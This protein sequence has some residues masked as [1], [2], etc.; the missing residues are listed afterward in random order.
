[1]RAVI[2]IIMST[3]IGSLAHAQTPTPMP[4]PASG[5]YNYVD[6]DS[7]VF[8][9]GAIVCPF[10]RTLDEYRDAARQNCF[11]GYRTAP[12]AISNLWIYSSDPNELPGVVANPDGTFHIG[13]PRDHCR[14]SV[15]MRGNLRGAGRVWVWVC[16]DEGRCL[17]VQHQYI[18]ECPGIDARIVGTRLNVNVNDGCL[19]FATG[20]EGLCTT[21]REENLNEHQHC[22]TMI[23]NRGDIPPPLPEQP[24][25]APPPPPAP[26]SDPTQHGN[27]G[28]TTSLHQIH[29]VFPGHD[30]IQ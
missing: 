4:E 29:C 27:S 12:T 24:T 2:L 26:P 7:D 18:P 5:P 22:L 15:E 6:A 9:E 28:H 13:G 30:S 10:C 14:Y 1:M 21:V 16:N 25:S 19:L 20:L 11:S 3:L 23:T 8:L 17:L